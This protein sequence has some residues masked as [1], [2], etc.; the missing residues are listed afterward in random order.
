VTDLIL[1]VLVRIKFKYT[2]ILTKPSL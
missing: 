1:P 2:I